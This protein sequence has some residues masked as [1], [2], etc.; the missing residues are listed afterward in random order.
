MNEIVEINCDIH[1]TIWATGV[2]QEGC[3]LCAEDFWR[4]TE[5]ECD[6]EI[7]GDTHYPCSRCGC[8]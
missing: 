4:R 5:H 2:T 1:G 6:D 8:V 3:P 7:I